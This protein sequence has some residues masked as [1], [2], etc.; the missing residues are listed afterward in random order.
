MT[1]HVTVREQK[2][3]NLIIKDLMFVKAF[4]NPALVSNNCKNET[5]NLLEGSIRRIE[6]AV[7]SILKGKGLL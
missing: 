5:L 6:I 4:I 7:F 1:N 2:T 3:V